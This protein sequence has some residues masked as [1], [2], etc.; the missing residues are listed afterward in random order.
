MSVNF[1]AALRDTN[2][3]DLTV[4]GRVSK[5][6]ITIPVWFVQEKDKVYLLPVRGSDSDWFKNLLAHPEVRLTAAGESITASAVPITD[7]AE[8]QRVVEKFRAK[9][10]ADDVAEYYPKTD[11]AAEVGLPSPG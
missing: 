4:T 5:R 3:I 11:V 9:Y 7:P 6:Q 8:V 2:Q 10:G 1:T